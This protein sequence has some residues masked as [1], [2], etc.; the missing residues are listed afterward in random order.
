MCR[1]FEAI[2]VPLEDSR[3]CK[4]FGDER[5]IGE[6]T[7]ILNPRSEGSHRGAGRIGVLERAESNEPATMDAI[8]P[9]A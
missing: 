3:F 4:T 9:A 6:E 2:N 5:I 1:L 7:F 8:L